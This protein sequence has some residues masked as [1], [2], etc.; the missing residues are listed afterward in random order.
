V[1]FGVTGSRRRMLIPVG[2]WRKVGSR[3]YRTRRKKIGCSSGGRRYRHTNANSHIL[4]I[5]I[6]QQEVKLQPEM[7]RLVELK[8]V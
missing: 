5:T 3:M 1:G 7:G 6:S 4:T 2:N 8:D